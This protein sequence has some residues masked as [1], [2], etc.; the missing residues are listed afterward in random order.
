MFKEYG[1]G[2]RNMIPGRNLVQ[3]TEMKSST[4]GKNKDNE[5]RQFVL[6]LIALKDNR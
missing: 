6:F 2:I 1:S 5:Q 3:N 4:N